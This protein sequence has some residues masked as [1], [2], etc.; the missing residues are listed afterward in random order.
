MPTVNWFR[1]FHTLGIRVDLGQHIPLRSMCSYCYRRVLRTLIG[2]PIEWV[3][4]AMMGA[5]LKEGMV[6]A[7]GGSFGVPNE[8]SNRSGNPVR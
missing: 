6:D 1:V 5:M 7:S 8:A 2:E 4:A 3:I